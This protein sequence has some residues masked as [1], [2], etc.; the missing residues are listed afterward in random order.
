MR[1]Y[2]LMKNKKEVLLTIIKQKGSCT[3]PIVI[4]C[5]IDTCPLRKSG[6]MCKY[7]TNDFNSYEEANKARLRTAVE[8]YVEKYNEVDIVEA[9]L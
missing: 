8:K 4:G 2:A 1:G 6:H 3:T 7:L 9:L 5:L